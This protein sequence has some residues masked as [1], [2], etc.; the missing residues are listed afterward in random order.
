MAIGT[1]FKIDKVILASGQELHAVGSQDH[2]FGIKPLVER[3]AGEVYPNFIANQ[4]Q[5]P[6]LNIGSKQLDVLL[7]NVPISGAFSLTNI[8]VY[9]KKGAGAGAV[10]RATTV[11]ERCVISQ[12]CVYWTSIRLM[13]NQPGEAQLSIVPSYDGTNDPIVFTGSV[14]LPTSLAASSYFGVGPVSIN[15]TAIPGIQEV[16]I[17][18]GIQLQQLGDASEEFDTFV[19]L[20]TGEVS[21]TIKTLEQTN[22]AALGLRGT[23]LDGTNGVIVYG[24]KFAA[25]GSRVAN[26][27]GEHLK[28]VGLSGKAIPQ[29]TNGQNADPVS[30]TIKVTLI[31]PTSSGSGLTT[32]VGTTIS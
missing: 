15:G 32:T 20:L 10:A 8:G 11:H 22:W 13:H 2:Q 1:I 9:L 18:S 24:R 26:G 4:E 27:T 31:S 21:I 29:N 17:E 25:G 16:T 7:A 3:A 6:V 12:A 5:K 19:G 28:F 14:A 23:V 30:D